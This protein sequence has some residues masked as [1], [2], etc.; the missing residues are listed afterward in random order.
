MKTAHLFPSITWIWCC[1]HRLQYELKTK[2]ARD[3]CI[4]TVPK[5]CL[6]E[7]NDAFEETDPYRSLLP[8]SQNWH[9]GARSIFQSSPEMR[10]DRMRL[11]SPSVDQEY[12]RFQVSLRLPWQ[13]FMGSGA[14]KTPK[15]L[16]FRFPS[17]RSMLELDQVSR[18]QL[19]VDATID[20]FDE[21]RTCGCSRSPIWSLREFL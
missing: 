19:C 3:L 15:Q 17:I 20:D 6:I 9:R 10:I 4:S 12:E 21:L 7:K 18:L 14:T 13:I 1:Y 8:E 16:L 11:S 5:V 2:D